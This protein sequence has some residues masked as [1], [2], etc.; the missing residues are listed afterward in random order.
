VLPGTSVQSSRKAIEI[1][2][3]HPEVFAAVGIHPHEADK[4][5][6]E[7]I[8]AIRKMATSDG[9]V[10]AIGEVGLDYYKGYSGKENQKRKD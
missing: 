7:D 2:G 6:A 5:T 8:D 9:K 4:V 1:A 3:K 10:V